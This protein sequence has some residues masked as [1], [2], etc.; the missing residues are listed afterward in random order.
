MSDASAPPAPSSIDA[1]VK[2][3]QLLAHDVRKPFTLLKT[4]LE[5]LHAQDA[6]E[7]VRRVV[8][9]LLPEVRRAIMAVNRTLG[10]IAQLSASEPPALE[11]TAPEALI[12]AA[13][14]E[15]FRERRAPEVQFH[16]DLAH[17]HMV[18]VDPARMLAAI[19]YALEFLATL[20]G[21]TGTIWFATRE[22]TGEGLCLEL[23]LGARA[24]EPLDVD[25]EH[26]FEPFAMPGGRRLGGLELVLARKIVEDHGGRIEGSV[27]EEQGIT[28]R[29]TLAG[30][31]EEPVRTTARLPRSAPEASSR[32]APQRAA[33][34]DEATVVK[35]RD[36]EA[37]LEQQVQVLSKQ[38]GRRLRV[39]VAD[40]E[41][42]YMI[43]IESKAFEHEEMRRILEIFKAQTAERALAM[44]DEL[45]PDA[46]ILDVVMGPG[47]MDGIE[48]A[49]VLRQHGYKGFIC[50]HS[51]RSEAEDRA[52]GSDCGANCFLR[53]PMS[54]AQLLR[55]LVDALP[56]PEPRPSASEP[57]VTTQ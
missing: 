52:A 5:L 25:P 55:I 27:S 39:L 24:A 49:R 40:D 44:V 29:M 19:S 10:E 30:L 28:L 16:Y 42:L 43:G 54:R 53:K 21:R 3:A 46:V 51:N 41:A 38:L 13:V 8:R 22:T 17:A 35:A 2:T 4:G 11:A 33:A 31:A 20:V 50:L 32:G 56:P 15:T 6:P 57:V 9:A 48:A 36:D 7:P 26:I 1:V 12:E 45:R 14:C 34:V 37:V 23:A 18:H 47:Q